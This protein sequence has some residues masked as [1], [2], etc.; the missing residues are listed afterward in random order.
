LGFK[1]D[2]FHHLFFFFSV[3]FSSIILFT[4]I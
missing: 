2:A 4:H 1:H 3:N